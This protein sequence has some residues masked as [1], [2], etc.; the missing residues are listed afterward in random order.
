MKQWRFG[1]LAGVL[2]VVFLATTVSASI[3]PIQQTQMVVENQIAPTGSLN[4]RV[5]YLTAT[6]QAGRHAIIKV[7]CDKFVQPLPEDNPDTAIN[8]PYNVLEFDLKYN[9]ATA[10]AIQNYE[11]RLPN[12]QLIRLF[13]V[14]DAGQLCR[15]DGTVVTFNL[16]PQ[17]EALKL[18]ALYGLTQAQLETY[19]DNNVTTLA[20]AKD[21]LKKLS[22][23]VL[24]LLKQSDMEK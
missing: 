6:Y 4:V 14:N 19:I 12:G 22:A 5:Y 18:S 24:Y 3:A 9:R 10:W 15:Q 17:V 21:Y 23:V 16:N 8:D 2:I 13:Y 7:W 20:N 11:M 1:L